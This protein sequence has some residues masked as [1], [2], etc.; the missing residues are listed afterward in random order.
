MVEVLKPMIKKAIVILLTN[1]ALITTSTAGDLSSNIETISYNFIQAK[2]KN[3][4]STDLN[5]SKLIFRLMGDLE[6]RS[7]IL[8]I[9]NKDKKTIG[10]F[11]PSSGSTLHRGEYASFKL[12]CLLGFNV[13]A[14][15]GLKSIDTKNQK[16]IVQ[17]LESVVFN[18]D[19]GKKFKKD[20]E[21]KEKNRKIIL[22]ELKQNI[23][24]D[25]ALEGVYKPW[26]KNISF[27]VPLG[28]IKGLKKHAIYKYLNYKAKQPPHKKINLK[29]CTKI[30]KPVGC[31]NGYAY[32]DNLSKDISSI[33]VLDSIMGNNDRFPGG[34]LHF[35]ALNN[36]EVVK[37]PKDIDF[38]EVRLFSLDNG[39][40]L[41]PKD[42][43]AFKILKNLKI[44]RFVKKHIDK[45]KE[46]QKT[47]D[48]ELK[49]DLGLNP[50]EFNIF[51]SN[52]SRTLAYINSLEKK[53]GSSIWF[54]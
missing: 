14:P 34:N 48:T 22:E 36:K 26:F 15:S 27:Y 17:L 35:R 6:G 42:K 29:Q 7:I 41:R 40:V 25:Q 5:N 13:Y 28:T 1:L 9:K 8:K 19:H 4:D 50:E 38:K 21:K 30:F 16:R 23:K 12:A 49:K 43:T 3:I 2:I 47:K 20:I 45:L 10:V 11:K 18:K 31:T 53:H 24:T 37:K 33:I 51:K 52:L 54:N 39:A 44:S 32:I 46:L